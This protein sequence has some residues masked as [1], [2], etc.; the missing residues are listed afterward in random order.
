IDPDN[1]LLWRANRKR[2]DGEALRDAMLAAGEQLSPRAGGVGIMAPLPPE[3]V[4]TLLKNQWQ[5]TKDNEDHRRRSI[6]LFVRRNLRY[7]MFEVFDRPDTNV[8]CAVR[9][10][11]TIAPQSLLLLNSEDSL[12]AATGLAALALVEGKSDAGQIATIYR[13]ALGRDPTEDEG[14]RASEFLAERIASFEAGKPA[15]RFTRRA[16]EL[17]D[18]DPSRLAA[19]SYL[20]LA[21]FNAS[22]FVYLD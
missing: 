17:G 19:L 22:E 4:V 21:L 11:S 9:P 2:L 3:L 12:E 15:K 18:A 1:R 10:R 5:P 6:Y 13:R 20:S 16:A 8:S 7:P 14:A